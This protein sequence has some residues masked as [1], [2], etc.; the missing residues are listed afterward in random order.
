MS[1]NVKYI[2]LFVVA[3]AVGFYVCVKYQE[4]KKTA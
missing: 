4:S 3:A 1:Q 2:L